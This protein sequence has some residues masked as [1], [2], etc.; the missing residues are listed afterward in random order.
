[1]YKI[2]ERKHNKIYQLTLPDRKYIIYPGVSKIK[3]FIDVFYVCLLFVDFVI[4]PFFYFFDLGC[5]RD[6]SSI[7]R[8]IIFDSFFTIEIILTFFTGYYNHSLNLIVTDHKAIA[9]YYLTHSFIVD[10]VAV[11]PFYV[12]FNN[13]HLLFIRMVK[14]YRYPHGIS[15]VQSFYSFIYGMCFKNLRSKTKLTEVTVFLISLVYILHLCSCIYLF[16]GL[17]FIDNYEETWIT[18]FLF[19][20]DITELTLKHMFIIYIGSAYQ[21][22]QTFT[23]TGYGDLVPITNVEIIFLMFCEI[24]NCG[25]FAYLLTCI[26]EIFNFRKNSLKF[27]YQVKTTDLQLWIAGFMNHLPQQSLEKNLHRAHIWKDVKRYF[28]LHYQT[29]RNFTWINKFEFLKQIKPLQRKELLDDAFD[30][31]RSKFKMFFGGIESSS[32]VNRI[33]ASMQTTIETTKHPIIRENDVLNRVYFIEQGMITIT[34]N[35][36]QVGVLQQGMVFG[37]EGLFYSKAPF[38]YAVHEAN[39]FTILYS[40]DFDTL[41]KDILSYDHQALEEIQSISNEYMR[42]VL[43]NEYAEKNIN[44][45]FENNDSYLTNEFMVNNV[46]EGQQLVDKEKDD[47]G[48]MNV[49]GSISDINKKINQYKEKEIELDEI[50]KKIELIESQLMFIEKNEK[51]CCELSLI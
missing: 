12:L 36:V 50:E 28:E 43:N 26:F 17:Y 27:K 34:K 46:L 49:L 6:V 3:P 33:I 15:Q 24:V 29:E 5:K 13:K 7:T 9:V 44:L 2:K 37:L 32:T 51:E 8:E 35:K 42:K 1:M 14:L 19:K 41:F 45:L 4:S 40:I 38:N 23:T 47:E 21:V 10:V 16:L 22:C 39:E 18:H 20:E 31:V 30:S 11:T 48:N 25:L